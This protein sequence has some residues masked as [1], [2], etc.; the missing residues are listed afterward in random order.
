MLMYNGHVPLT[1]DACEPCDNPA[2][3]CENCGGWQYGSGFYIKWS[4]VVCLGC[5]DY[6]ETPMYK[7]V[8]QFVYPKDGE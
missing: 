7:A 1:H 3:V 6:V 5:F 4:L 2:F 8:G